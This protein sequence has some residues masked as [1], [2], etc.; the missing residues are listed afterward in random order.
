MTN[1]LQTLIQQL[2]TEKA[3]NEAAILNRTIDYPAYVR[4]AMRIDREIRNANC[5]LAAQFVTDYLAG[6][7][8]EM[9]KRHAV[10]T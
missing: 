7:E 2:E 4:E 10:S 1:P 3:A 5:L 9:R 8:A 6:R